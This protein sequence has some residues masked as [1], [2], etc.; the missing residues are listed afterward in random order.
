MNNHFIFAQI[1]NQF[2]P[3]LK[4]QQK[5]SP[6]QVSTCQNILNCHTDKLGG[7]DYQCDN[8]HRHTLYYHSCRHRH[9]P[10]CQ[11]KAGEQWVKKRQQDTLPLIYYHMV[12]TLPHE[13]NAW[14]QLHPEVIYRLLFNSVWSTL[15]DYSKDNKL[16]QGQLGMVTVLHSWG[17][18][19]KQHNHLH[20][21]IPGGVLNDNKFTICK[22][23]YL[24]PHKALTKVYR[25]KMVSA[26]RAAVKKGEL[27]RITQPGQVDDTLNTLMK[28]NWVINTK[29]HINSPDTVV[30][31]LGRYTYRTAISLSRIQSVDRNTVSF[32]WLDYR[33]NQ[34]K[35]LTLNGV[36]FLQRFL[37]HVL[38]KGFM[39]IRHFGYLANCIRVKSLAKIRHS[40]QLQ[41]CVPPLTKRTDNM[42]NPGQY[43]QNR[44]NYEK[45][46]C[47]KCKK[48][49][50]QLV[51]EIPSE[52]QRRQDNTIMC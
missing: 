43:P 19:L 23:K 7:L 46:P 10:Q 4:Q 52:K 41:T 21:L 45:V 44:E 25:G 6:Q 29:P 26:L 31:Y 50:L 2:L 39:R 42:N 15:N 20:C 18:N 1:I 37:S 51:G 13:L 47:P 11:Q 16:M 33:D 22:R 8:C 30:N 32:K 9:C 24:Y 3:A 27:H 34:H 40:L 49:C 35:A 12:F 5:L 36:D 17:Q 38:P 28:K 14:V 48:G